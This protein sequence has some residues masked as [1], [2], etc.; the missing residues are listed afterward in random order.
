MTGDLN[1]SQLGAMLGLL[2]IANGAFLMALKVMFDRNT[3]HIDQRLDVFEESIDK[4]DSRIQ[5]LELDVERLRGDIGKD[6]VRRE[7]WIRLSTQL[8]AKL[9]RLWEAVDGMK[10]RPGNGR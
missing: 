8:D 7:D 4:T 2:T 6:Y 10:V 5:K 9:D 1:W 3:K